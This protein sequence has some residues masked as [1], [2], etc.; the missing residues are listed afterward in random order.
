[1]SA[2]RSA[3]GAHAKELRFVFC[4]QGEGSKGVRDFLKASYVPLKSANPSFPLLV[5]D[6]TGTE[7][8]VM[9]RYAFGKEASV[10]VEKLSAADIEAK[11]AAL[12]GSSP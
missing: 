6:S 9:A 1:M 2:W 11:V 4:G 8:R 3:L 5:R 12:V 10:S 7:A